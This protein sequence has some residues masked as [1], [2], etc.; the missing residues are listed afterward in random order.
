MVVETLSREAKIILS[1]DCSEWNDDFFLELTSDL[2]ELPISERNGIY[3]MVVA[4]MQSTLLYA[5]SSSNL[6]G[7]VYGH[8]LKMNNAERGQYIH[9]R[10]AEESGGIPRFIHMGSCKLG[11]HNGRKQIVESIIVLAMDLF[12]N[13]KKDTKWGGLV[14]NGKSADVEQLCEGCNAK[15]LIARPKPSIRF[16]IR[17]FKGCEEESVNKDQ[18]KEHLRNEHDY[19]D[20]V[21]RVLRGWCRPATLPLPWGR[22]DL[23]HAYKLGLQLSQRLER[24]MQEM[25]RR[26]F[27]DCKALYIDS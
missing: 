18:L 21:I 19:H 3:L 20:S 5:G 12:S 10:A 9:R 2:D 17:C 27:A 8:L 26:I 14:A 4:T 11:N 22:G 25:S 15:V 13:S 7:R 16:T 6:P 24:K 23:F 1:A